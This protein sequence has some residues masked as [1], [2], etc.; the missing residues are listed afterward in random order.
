MNKKIIYI[1]CCLF[2]LFMPIS[3]VQAKTVEEL[4]E[5]QNP[6]KLGVD[7]TM[8]GTVC[9][10]K[11]EAPVGNT[12]GKEMEEFKVHIKYNEDEKKNV[13]STTPNTFNT[14]NNPE[15]K[16]DGGAIALLFTHDK[17]YYCPE[18]LYLHYNEITPSNRDS[19][20]IVWTLS[21][22][23]T[24]KWTGDIAPAFTG[25]VKLSFVPETDKNGKVT[26][27]FN[28]SN[29]EGESIGSYY[30][31]LKKVNYV[32]G[33]IVSDKLL[34]EIVKIYK[35]ICL[36]TVAVVIILGILD[37]MKAISSDDDSA[38]KKA[39]STFIKR[40]VV[41]IILVILPILLQFI[42]TIFGDENMKECLDKI[43]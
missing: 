19:H 18:V 23:D 43:K 16:Y 30:P 1:V 35:T 34:K 38:L 4:I 40:I 3:L 33:G 36:V 41:V 10:Y 24:Y 25:Y 17:I 32:C 42:L 9:T 31:G 37:F 12:N 11:G 20:R 14:T 6:L 28:G 5:E 2:T 13:F 15:L 21:P 39:A 27:N 22:K 26:P 7:D 29:Q 8:T